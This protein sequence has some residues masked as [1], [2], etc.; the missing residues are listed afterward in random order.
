[1]KKNGI[2]RPGAIVEDYVGIT[3][4]MHKNLVNLREFKMNT[5]SLL[6]FG[7]ENSVV[8]SEYRCYYDINTDKLLVTI[9]PS[10]AYYK[11]YNLVFLER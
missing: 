5:K 4:E 2:K 7:K 3:K 9:R 6:I 8:R 10:P 1:V 11:D